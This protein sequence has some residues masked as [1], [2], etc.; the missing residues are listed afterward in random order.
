MRPHHAPEVVL[1]EYIDGCDHGCDFL[2]NEI[3]R[4]LLT[5]PPHEAMV[6]VRLLG[7]LCPPTPQEMKRPH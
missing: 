6:L 2:I 5:L 1:S 7:Y 4:Y 3:R